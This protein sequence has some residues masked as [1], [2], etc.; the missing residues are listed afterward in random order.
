M[1]SL[2]ARDISSRSWRS[3]C[4]VTRRCGNRRERNPLFSVLTRCPQFTTAAM[5][6]THSRHFTHRKHSRH[7]RY[8]RHLYHS[9]V[10]DNIRSMTR[11]QAL[12]L[13]GIGA[14][15]VVLPGQASAQ[16]P[17]FPKGVVIRTI[18][19]DYAPEELAGG[20]TLFHEHM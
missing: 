16:S 1:T 11:R 3:I 15:A 18:L 5:H 19:R 9:A 7:P 14:A 17:A 20:A 6:S 8:P 2:C 12:E 13:L 10:H 4:S